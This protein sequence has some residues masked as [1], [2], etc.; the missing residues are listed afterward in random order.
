VLLPGTQY[1]SGVAFVSDGSY[2]ALSKVTNPDGSKT[3]LVF[4]VH[5]YLD[6][7]NSGTHSNCVTDNTAGLASLQSTLASAGRQAILSETG[8]GSSDSSCL[9]DVC[10]EIAYINNHSGQFLGYTGWSAGSFDTS[11]VLSLTPTYSNGKWTDVPLMKC[12]QRK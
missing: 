3:N 5:Q 12:F 2:A 6:S 11:Y 8:G 1:T 10:A 7:D 4:D 9:T